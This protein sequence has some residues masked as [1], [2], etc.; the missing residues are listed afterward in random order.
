MTHALVAPLLFGVKWLDPEWMLSEF[1]SAFFWVSLAIIVVECGLF[2]FLPR[3]PLVA[4]ARLRARLTES[5]QWHV[6]PCGGRED[7]LAECIQGCGV[8]HGRPKPRHSH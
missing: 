1:G 5:E 3:H 8:S 7:L 2:P 6:S 4:R